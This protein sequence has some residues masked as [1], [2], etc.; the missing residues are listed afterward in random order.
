LLVLSRR[1]GQRI[2]IEPSPGVEIWLAVLD[3]G[4]DGKVRIGIEAPVSMP[5]VREELLEGDRRGD[6]GGRR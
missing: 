4:Y 2:R 5:V 1:V 6:A 3:V